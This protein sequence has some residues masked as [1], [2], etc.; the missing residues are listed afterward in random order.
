MAAE[1]VLVKTEREKHEAR[2]AEVQQ[3]VKDAI[4]KCEDFEQKN[5]EHATALANLKME[6][7][8]SRSETR[9]AREE[10]QKVKQI[11]NC[12]QYLL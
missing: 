10:L 3:E 12:K 6:I 5:K 2:V 8:E 4:T 9:S 7:Q 1:L 11:S